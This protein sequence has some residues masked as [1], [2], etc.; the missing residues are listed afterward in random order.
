MNYNVDSCG[1]V[2]R[3]QLDT[4]TRPTPL[5]SGLRQSYGNPGVSGPV[6]GNQAQSSFPNGVFALW[7]RKLLWY[8]RGGIRRR[9]P[10]ATATRIERRDDQSLQVSN[11]AART[12]VALWFADRCVRYVSGASRPAPYTSMPEGARWAKARAGWCVERLRASA[13]LAS[14]LVNAMRRH[15]SVKHAKADSVSLRYG[16]ALLKHSP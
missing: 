10:V 4:A 16:S 6:C 3:S 1:L 2:T 15:G 8:G 14:S 12:K 11:P 7:L 9:Q 5:G 13:L